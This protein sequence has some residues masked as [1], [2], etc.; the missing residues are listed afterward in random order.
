M[1]LFIF[2]VVVVFVVVLF[3]TLP[4]DTIETECAAGLTK[5]DMECV[6]LTSNEFC[7]DCFTN[8]ST[9]GTDYECTGSKCTCPAGPKCACGDE[10]DPCSGVNQ[11]CTNEGCMCNEA[12]GVFF[13]YCP[14]DGGTCHNLDVE[15]ENCGACG[16]DCATKS[17]G[18]G[19]NVSSC[20]GDGHCYCS[21]DT[22]QQNP[23]ATCSAIV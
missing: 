2:A 5:C 6:D 12:G 23:D 10:A 20:G 11:Y 15:D 17:A 18:D 9:V 1:K 3:Q 7:G 4:N 19:S 14:V 16:N 13:T 21:D 22:S 8:C